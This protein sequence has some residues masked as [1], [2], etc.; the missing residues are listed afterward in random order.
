MNLGSIK[1]TM[2]IITMTL[3]AEAAL[4]K[5]A[6]LKNACLCGGDDYS[7]YDVEEEEK[8]QVKCRR[9][10][11]TTTVVTMMII[12]AMMMTKTLSREVGS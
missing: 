12:K 3:Q 5:I 2:M 7:Y 1:M 9:K 6:R 4:A 11:M 10:M 8:R